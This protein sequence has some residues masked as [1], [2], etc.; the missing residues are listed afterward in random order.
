MVIAFAT[1]LANNTSLRV[2]RLRGN[3]VISE[4]GKNALVNLLADKTSI[5][6][7]Y[8]SNHTLEE[9]TVSAPW[10]G[11]RIVNNE[12]EDKVEVARQKILQYL[13][14]DGDVKLQEFL[15]MDIQLCPAR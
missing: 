5:N 1:A 3:D 6:T 8:M 7:M 12:N 9:V 4:R 11:G 15:V 10:F 2:L 14:L 13:F